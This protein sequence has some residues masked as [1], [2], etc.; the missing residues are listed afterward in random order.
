MS[1][2]RETSWG[3]T[4]VDEI[5]LLRTQ[6]GLITNCTDRPGLSSVSNSRWRL[7]TSLE[8]GIVELTSNTKSHC[9]SAYFPMMDDETESSDLRYMVLSRKA[10][11]SSCRNTIQDGW[12]WTGIPTA[13]GTLLSY[14]EVGTTEAKLRLLLRTIGKCL[15]TIFNLK[16]KL[17]NL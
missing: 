2:Q 12:L 6:D 14:S 16:Q 4:L 10:V 13:R 9:Y 1:I 11:Y 7:D 8:L 17:S 15:I 3:R 5:S